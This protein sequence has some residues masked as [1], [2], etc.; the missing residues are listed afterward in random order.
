M[1]EEKRFLFFRG[2][3]SVNSVAVGSVVLLILMAV[4]A[5]SIQA[6]VSMLISLTICTLGIGLVIWLC[7]A[8]LIG[9][10]IVGGIWGIV[11]FAGIVTE[12][13]TS[14]EGETSGESRPQ[15][16]L[17]TTEL[18]LVDYTV[19]AKERGFSDTQIASRLQS[20][21]WSNE[22]IEL[23]QGLANVNLRRRFEG[24]E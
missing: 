9:I 12:N 11:K 23:A 17:S 18:A 6:A 5:G 24:N 14:T 7:F 8:W 1:N 22:E 19:K 15:E 13:L 20:Q 3:L 4:T 10:V 16:R 21:G 2:E